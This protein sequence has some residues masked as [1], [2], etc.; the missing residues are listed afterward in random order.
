MGSRRGSLPPKEGDLRHVCNK[1]G[2]LDL[3]QDIFFLSSE[4]I[5]QISMKL[6]RKQVP[7]RLILWFLFADPSRKMATLASD[8]LRNFQL[9]LF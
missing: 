1:D 7:L 5:E 9:F 6:D 3:G 8:W 2:C 4:T